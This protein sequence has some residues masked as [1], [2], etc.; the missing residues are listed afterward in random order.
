MSNTGI[1]NKRKRRVT[2]TWVVLFYIVPA[3][4]LMR[5]ALGT[6][7]FI[8]L[9][10]GE[11]W[12]RLFVTAQCE[13]WSQ[14]SSIG[15]I[16][17]AAFPEVARFWPVDPLVQSISVPLVSLWG[18][19]QGWAVLLIGLSWLAGI[20]G[21][22]VARSMGASVPVALAGGLLTQLHPTWLRHAGEGVVE[23]LCLGALAIAFAAGRRLFDL[24]TDLARWAA[25]VGA[26]A[27]VCGT[28]PYFAIYAAVGVL[29]AVPL[30]S[31]RQG[32]AL[33]LAL[34]VLLFTVGC[35]F[36]APLIWSEWGGRLSG[37]W[38]GGYS[39]KPAEMVILGETTLPYVRPHSGHHSVPVWHRVLAEWPGG[40]AVS[41][42]LGVG[43]YTRASRKIA[44]FGVLWL[45]AGP[46]WDVAARWGGYPE[47]SSPLTMLLGVLPG[48]EY[49]GNPQ[50]MVVIPM[51]L[52]VATLAQL[53]HRS[54]A[55]WVGALAIGV[56]MVEVPTLRL[57][58]ID[59]QTPREL[60]PFIE[61]P[62]VTF[63]DG[64]PPFW[65]VQRYPKEG[66]WMAGSHGGAQAFDFGRG[67]VPADTA[68][69]VRLSRI[70]GIPLG[71][72]AAA[73][74]SDRPASV[75]VD[76]LSSTGFRSVFVLWRGLDEAEQSALQTWL[77]ENLG[78]PVVISQSGGVWTVP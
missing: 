4:F 62:T 23:V 73:F 66:L 52:A 17:L 26:S 63:P 42:L 34:L 69:K 33:M 37:D 15:F 24:P 3:A 28:S 45:A 32:R 54:H 21:F 65:H 72:R 39:L 14:G 8:G 61:G 71:G 53:R 44:A 19:A 47:L 77:T 1:D 74:A 55:V 2:S 56:A 40:L 64:D 51:I 20:G 50:R 76:E 18:E 5:E 68:F 7:K 70:S 59:Y 25:F 46:G 22:A 38:Q 36:A 41:L 49:L 30:V 6:Q 31:G 16:D 35:L 12:G 29:F 78:S 13:R 75:L 48:A 11:I 43:L 57:P 9:A 10:W 60:Y 67:A 58:T 27:L